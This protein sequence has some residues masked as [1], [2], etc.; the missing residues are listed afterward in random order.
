MKPTFQLPNYPIWVGPL[1]Q[2]F[3]A[4]FESAG[5]T[6]V[7]LIADAETR[8]HCLP[9]FLQETGLSP[10]VPGTTI[11]A[12]EHFKNMHTCAHIWQ[13]MLAA[14]LDR[15]A[16]VINLGGGVVGDMGGFCAATYKRGV[17]FVQIPTTLLSMTDASVGGKLGIDFNGI[18]NAIGLFGDP[19]AVFADP[20]FFNTLS[21]RELRSGFAE[22]IKHAIIG[23]AELWDQLQQL[24]DLRVVHWPGL[25][26]ASIAVKVKVVE[27]DPFEKNLRAV[28]NF[29]HTIGHAIESYFLNSDTPLTHG[30][31]I[32]I[33]MFCEAELAPA[34]TRLPRAA[35]AK[36]LR[37]FFPYRAI[38]AEAFPAL[39]ELMQQDKKNTSGKVRIALPDAEPCRL[40]VLEPALV[41][42]ERS[43][44][45]YNDTMRAGL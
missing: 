7:F 21:E 25:L 39:W 18:K 5:Y 17:D 35:L 26:K 4:W 15:K 1:A 13:D 27:L 28:L 41:E 30:E 16:L 3:P 6:Q 31:A 44:T 42:L 2:T 43:L 19:V 9:I 14:G 34:S 12:G 45:V 33:G 20:I 37:R 38:P 24:A 32:A 11:P 22:V 8:K 10:D 29:G 40:H 23:D 36:L